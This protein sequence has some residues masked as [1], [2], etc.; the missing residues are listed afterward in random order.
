MSNVTAANLN[1]AERAIFENFGDDPFADQLY[2]MVAKLEESSQAESD[3]HFRARQNQYDKTQKAQRDYLHGQMQYDAAPE[4]ERTETARKIL[5]NL[6]RRSELETRKLNEFGSAP[7]YDGLKLQRVAKWLEAIQVPQEPIP[8]R[9]EVANAT[10]AMLKDATAAVLEKRQTWREILGA[11]GTLPE[12]IKGGERWLES[13]LKKYRRP[14]YVGG[15]FTRRVEEDKGRSIPNRVQAP[16]DPFTSKPDPLA[17]FLHCAEPLVRATLKQRIT[18]AW[19]LKYEFEGP[20]SEAER[21]KEAKAAKAELDK[22][23]Q[24]EAAVIRSLVL[25]GEPIVIRKDI[26]L[27]T[28][29]GTRANAD[30][31]AEH[32]AEQERLRMN[33]AAGPTTVLREDAGFAGP[34]RAR[35]AS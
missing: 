2:Q 27:R 30:A 6:K 5:A 18:E 10:P 14:W 7:V 22:A 35:V 21:A 12:A 15:A 23:E 17:L 34:G 1:F 16:S 31:K 25:Q 8:G 33:A 13:F 20:L 26:N 4:S 3:A 11:P 28:L 29:F 32:D 19:Q 9:K 24:H